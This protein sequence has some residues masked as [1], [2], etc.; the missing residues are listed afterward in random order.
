MLLHLRAAKEAG[1]AAGRLYAPSRSIWRVAT[2]IRKESI[3]AVDG[4]GDFRSH[5][6]VKGDRAG[7][8]LDRVMFAALAFHL[9]ALHLFAFAL[10]ALSMCHFFL[11]LALALQNLAFP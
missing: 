4:V 3:R 5:G 2:E 6:L 1:R 9:L 10:V 8:T 7:V 11:A